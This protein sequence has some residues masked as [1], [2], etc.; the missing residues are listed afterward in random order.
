M[1]VC[2][3][4]YQAVIVCLD[5]SSDI[6]QIKPKGDI[7]SRVTGSIREKALNVMN[8]HYEHTISVLKVTAGVCT[9]RGCAAVYGLHSSTVLQRN[10]LHRDAL[11][12]LFLTS[13]C[14]LL[15]SVQ[16]FFFSSSEL[17]LNVKGLPSHYAIECHY[18][19]R[20]TCGLNL[21]MM[22]WI[23]WHKMTEY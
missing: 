7:L 8:A 12:Y 21:M 5:C 9:V 13:L 4:Y 2:F 19:H 14:F 20:S 23:Y 6:Q 18:A 17:L 11:C 10:W 16:F 1:R 22:A 15:S 3:A